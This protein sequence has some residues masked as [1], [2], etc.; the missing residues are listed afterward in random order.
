MPQGYLDGEIS[1]DYTT[2]T[3]TLDP[4]QIKYHGSGSPKYFGS[5]INT[6]NYRNFELSFNIIYKFGYYFRRQD[7][8]GGSNYGS[9]LTPLYKLADYE[10]RWQEPGDELTT[11]IPALVYPNSSSRTNFF[12]YSESLVENGSHIRL[13]DIRLSY[14]IPQNLYPRF[15]FKA[16][17]IFFYA[18][19]LGIL[20][21][22]NK[23]GIDPDYPRAIPQ[24]FSMSIGVNLNL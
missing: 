6:F 24:P 1:T 15:P 19:N 22:A 17:N 9:S 21:R 16:A 7:V 20:W 14:T 5:L 2:I 13:Q 3:S 8:F 23:Q 12:A 4:D 11:N 18:R 10:K